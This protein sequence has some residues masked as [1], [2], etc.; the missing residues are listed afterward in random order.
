MDLNLGVVRATFARA[1]RSPADLSADRL[2]DLLVAHATSVPT[3]AVFDEFSA[4]QSV[5]GAAG[6]LRTKLQHQYQRIGLVFAGSEPSTMRMLFEESDQPFYAQAD[7][8]HV[9][10]LS[11][12]AFT[13]IVASGFDDAPGL[14][15]NI[16]GLTGGHPQRSMQLADAAWNAVLDGSTEPWVDALAEVRKA[17]APGHE[18][19]FSATAPADQIVLRLV[20]V[21]EPLFGRAAELLELSRSSAQN[22][23]RR[24]VA[25]GQI[26]DDDGSCAVVDP[27]YGDWIAHRFPL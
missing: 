18:T 5:D 23:R 3:V 11:L 25:T 9:P 17:T 16:H 6:L 4:V 10:L 22:S 15:G 12:S 27:L 2:L 20:A 14:A 7:L 24:L 21:K 13:D 26:A 1:D 8:V 19:R